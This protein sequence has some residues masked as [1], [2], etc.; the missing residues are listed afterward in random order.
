ML[1]YLFNIVLEIWGMVF[2]R[3]CHAK[4][5]G[6]VGGV[7]PVPDGPRISKSQLCADL[8]A[9]LIRLAPYVIKAPFL[10]RRK[11]NWRGVF[12]NQG[13]KIWLQKV[14]RTTFVGFIK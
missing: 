3:H 9:V 10:C 1:L 12:G 5:L 11:G 2:Q 6:G 13:L 4:E 8:C 14:N 7:L